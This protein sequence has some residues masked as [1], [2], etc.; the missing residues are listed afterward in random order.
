MGRYKKKEWNAKY[1]RILIYAEKG[2]PVP[3]IAKKEGMH[4]QSVYRIM[5]DNRFQ[6]R[7]EEFEDK[8]AD[9]ARAIF[10]EHA[11]Q[12]AKKIV[13]I[14]KGGKSEDRIKFEAAKEVLYQV[15]V[16]PVEVIETR[17]RE[18]SPEELASMSKTALEL[19]NIVNRLSV[20][21]SRFLLEDD[22]KR[23]VTK[24]E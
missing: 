10:E 7:K 11:I 2:M 16:K 14:A 6:A 9:K 22:V 13:A 4:L 1:Q 19:E 3:D 18:Y 15:G 21:K 20:K 24:E 12:A 23:E 5:N 8:I 17:K